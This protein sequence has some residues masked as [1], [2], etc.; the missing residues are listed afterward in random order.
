MLIFHGRNSEAKRK[1]IDL[2]VAL[3]LQQSRTTVCVK[4]ETCRAQE[5]AKLEGKA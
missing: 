4:N 3:T 2:G 5:V 1:G